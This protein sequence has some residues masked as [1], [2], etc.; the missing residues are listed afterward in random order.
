VDVKD[1]RNLGIFGSVTIWSKKGERER[2]ESLRKVS[3]RCLTP[4]FLFF[5]TL[6]FKREKEK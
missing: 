6:F 2:K 3:K 1:K 4:Y 5:D